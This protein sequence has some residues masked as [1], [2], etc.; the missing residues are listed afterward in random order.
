MNLNEALQE[1]LSLEDQDGQFLSIYLN[2]SV[3]QQ[4]KR[5]YGLFFDKQLSRLEKAL[6]QEEDGEARLKLFHADVDRARRYLNLELRKDTCGVAILVSAAR[7]YFRALQLPLPVRNKL[8]LSRSPNL[9]IL[10]ELAEENEHYCVALLDQHSGRIFSVYL[11]HV[12]ATS[13]MR[14]DR[15]P[16]RTKVGGWS[17]MRYQRHRK[18]HILHFMREL[19]ELLERFVRREKPDRI[20]LLGTPANVSEFRKHLGANLARKI[21]LTRRIPTD[22]D[23]AELVSKIRA[24]I[25]EMKV[26][27]DRETAEKLYQQLW[28]NYRA[29]VGLEGTLYNLQMG[30]LEKLIISNFLDGRGYQ[31]SKCD[32][33][34]GQ[35]IRRC[36]YCRGI[37]REVDIRNRL[38]KIAEQQKVEIEVLSQPTF[39]DS[40]GGAG[41]FLKF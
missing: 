4:G 24:S 37:I 22:V 5:D 1:L 29:V 8:V 31:C 40:V 2:T 17:Q 11:Y 6:P 26:Y 33:L 14:D 18:D 15:V 20:I 34:F 23:E 3:N 32:F 12:L 38:E 36:T 9:D 21:A 7:R 25:E 35:K 28:Q 10:I 19:A 41:G 39:L 27:Q 13:S 16:G 30:K